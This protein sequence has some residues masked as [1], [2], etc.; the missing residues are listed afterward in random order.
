MGGLEVGADVV[1]GGIVIGEVI[2][3]TGLV[4]EER[5]GDRLVRLLVAVEIQPGRLGLGADADAAVTLEFL[6]FAVDRGLRAQLQSA[7]LLGGVQIALEQ[8]ENAPDAQISIEDEPLPILPTIPANLSDFADTAQG[9]FNRV[10]ALPIEE[11]LESALTVMANVNSLL[12]SE[13]TVE[14]PGEVLSLLGD[15]RSLV[16]SEGVQNIPGQAADVM[17]TLQNS[18]REIDVLVQSLVE[19]GAAEALVQALESADEAANTVYEAMEEV[20]ETLDG[21]DAAIASLDALIQDVD[22]LPIDMTVDRVNGILTGVEELV[23]APA[24]QALP[25]DVQAT[26]QRV[27]DLL[28]QLRDEGIVASAAR[29]IE[30]TE[31]AVQDVAAAL[32][33]ILQEARRAASAVAEAAEGTPQ[34]VARANQIAAEL[35]AL[36]GE[37]SELPLDEL[38]NR[39]SNLLNT[40]NTLLGSEDVARL[41]GALSD[42]LAEV[43]RVL[44]QVQEGGLVENANS[45]LAAAEDAA[46]Q[47]ARAAQ[48]LPSIASRLNTVLAEAEELISGYQVNGSLGSEA[49][50]TLRDIRAAAKS[51]DSLTRAIERNPNS[52]LFGR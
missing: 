36:V 19:A 25:A 14:T 41:P 45:T 50:S 11:L 28:T 33:P 1:F 52:L 37:A 49:R 15:V 9:V 34:I 44:I 43:Q 46:T 23:T 39:A 40:A 12:T 31:T 24:T 6:E 3:L 10:N 4:D 32:D 26:L 5:F 17:A 16:A 29:T 8:V 13:G 27:Q 48:Q 30:A 51:V 7:G 22:A 35:E 47:I 20:P 2:S 21:V 18:A 42:A 38:A